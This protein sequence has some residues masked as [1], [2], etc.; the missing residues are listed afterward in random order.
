MAT[1]RRKDMEY[2]N[3]DKMTH[4]EKAEI[5][6]LEIDEEKITKEKKYEYVLQISKELHK[7]CWHQMQTNSAIRSK[8]S[9]LDYMIPFKRLDFGNC[10]LDNLTDGGLID[11][12]KFK[13]KK[14]HIPVDVL[15]KWK[16]WLFSKKGDL[17]RKKAI[18]EIFEQ[19]YLSLKEIF[20]EM[21]QEIMKK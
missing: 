7:V 11:P 20:E 8:Y 17:Q 5:M 10:I 15:E 13:L 3:V 21:K 6:F 16:K 9:G 12:E 14:E 19:V 2:L 18:E 4:L 1:V